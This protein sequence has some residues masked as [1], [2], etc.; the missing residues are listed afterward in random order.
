MALTVVYS[1][2]FGGVFAEN[3]GGTV[4]NYVPDTLGSTIGL[5]SST[6][7][8]T[9]RWEY[10]PYGEAV[11]RSGSNVTPLTFLGIL[12]YFQDVVSQFFYVRARHLRVD[13]ARWLTVDPL[14]PK[15]HPYVYAGSSPTGVVDPSGRSVPK[16][17]PGGQ[18]WHS[19]YGSC[20]WYSGAENTLYDYDGFATASQGS[21]LF[22]LCS[23]VAADFAGLAGIIALFTAFLPPP[24]GQLIT[25][26][27][28]AVALLIAL[29][30]TAADLN[31]LPMVCI[32]VSFTYVMVAGLPV[33]MAGPTPSCCT[34]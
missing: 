21:V 23:N 18:G 5:T 16:D 33:F 28:G 6:G 10:W 24:F 26:L 11:S 3:R 27:L 14:W 1:N 20:A 22:C 25:L 30:A 19:L 13:L 8:L 15:Q 34:C 7:T 9:D 29:C 17:V 12:G 2:A 4:S 31:G 32:E